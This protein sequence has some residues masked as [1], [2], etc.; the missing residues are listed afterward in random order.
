MIVTTIDSASQSVRSFVG[1]R[2]LSNFSLFAGAIL[3]TLVACQLSLAAPINYGTFNGN[4]VQYANVT[5]DS[6]SG[7][8][9]PLFGA[10][11][12][13]GDSIDFNPV[14]FNAA[15]TGGGA[16]ITDSNLAMGINALPG[17]AINN[18]SFSEAGDATLAGIGTD[19]TLASVTA[20]GI[21]NIYEVDG[22][23]TF[24][25]PMPIALTFTPSNGDY[26]LLA[27]AGGGPFYHTQ[28]SGSLFLDL[29]AILTANS[30]P[31]NFGVTKLSINIDNTLTAVSEAGTTSLIAKKNF[32]GVSITVNVPEPASL[33]L[34]VMASLGLALF[35][36]S[37]RS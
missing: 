36:R 3:L 8:P 24:V 25:A 12:V 7:D 35:R 17:Y 4:T 16:D 9:L 1:G 5:E 13:S 19:N 23:G 27:D 6:N 29:D 15:S 34:I 22:V 28:W 30:I 21:L 2:R 14:G 31:F 26:K 20:D 37:S 18:I 11:T 10:P 33:A 32:G